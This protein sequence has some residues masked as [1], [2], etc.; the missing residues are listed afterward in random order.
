MGRSIP[1]YFGAPRTISSIRRGGQ[2]LDVDDTDL[3][4]ER[5]DIVV[6]LGTR[7]DIANAEQVLLAGH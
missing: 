6:L 1:A 3:V 7:S 2:S 4:L 5:G